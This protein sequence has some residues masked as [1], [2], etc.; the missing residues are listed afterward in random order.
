MKI[1]F[2]IFFLFVTIN[3]YSQS[4]YSIL[5][6]EWIKNDS[7]IE[8]I[9]ETTTNYNPSSPEILKSTYHFDS[10]G[11]QIKRDDYNEDGTIK[12][13]LKYHYDSDEYLISR[14]FEN[15]INIIGYQID[16]AIYKYDST[17]LISIYSYDSSGLLK[18][19]AIIENKYNFPINLVSYYPN[20][21]VIG[22]EKA[23]YVFEINRAF[24][25]VYNKSGFQIG[26]PTEHPISFEKEKEI[27]FSSKKYNEKGDLIEYLTKRCYACEDYVT[28]QIE[29]K[30]N[31]NNH[32]IRE[33]RYLIENNKRKK[34]KLIKRKIKYR[35]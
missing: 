26:K 13:R 10:K 32:W 1:Y 16:S 28:Y 31:K 6:Q 24:I 35:F 11:L 12:A 19:Y 25:S 5:R 7:T 14:T 33:T 21:N 22:I 20:G 15:W 27:D 34:T 4:I 18:T 17:G 29:Y 8:K 9:I 2:I 30:Y 23:T 3:T